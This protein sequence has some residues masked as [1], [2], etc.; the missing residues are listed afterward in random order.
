MIRD[1]E[2]N[3]RLNQRNI[4]SHSLKPN[5]DFRSQPTKYTD[6]QTIDQDI[7]PSVPLMTYSKTGFNPGYRGPTDEFLEKID[8][9][10][11]LRNQYM[12]LQRNS[13]AVYVPK[14]NSDLYNNPMNYEKEY[15]TYNTKQHRE[16][17]KK[18][19]P[20]IFHNSTRYYLK[21]E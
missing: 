10:S 4:P 16:N 12:A 13:Q 18:L 17:C 15:S 5:F 7:E 21:K 14:M 11:Y 8:L 9:E 6:F 2:L 19:D 1:N 3:V 20:N